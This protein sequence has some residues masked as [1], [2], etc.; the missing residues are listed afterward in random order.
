MQIVEEAWNASFPWSHEEVDAFRCLD[1]KLRNTAKALKSWSAKHIGSVRLQLAI[2]KEIVYRLDWAQD[3]SSLATQELALK[4]KAKLCYLGLASLQRT[5]VRQRSRITFLAEG[6]ANT[7]IFHLQACHR[8]R[9]NVITKL[10]V[11]DTIIMQDDQMADQ[12]FQHFSNIIGTPGV[13]NCH[14]NLSELSFPSVQ[15]ALLDTYFTEEEVWQAILDMPIDKALGSD[16]FTGLF[17][18]IAWPIIKPDIM[19]AFHALWS[20]DGRNLHLLNQAFMILLRKKNL[21]PS[22]LVTTDL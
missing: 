7:K 13:Q 5:L 2:A 22:A 17:Y 19:Q 9:K 20:L 15:S 6:D 14:L 16:G 18:R 8:N 1:F 10:R 4:R 21:M 12:V 11:D 3:H